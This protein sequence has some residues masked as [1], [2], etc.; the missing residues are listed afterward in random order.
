M[1]LQSIK[2]S[3]QELLIRVDE[4]PEIIDEEEYC[5]IVSDKAGVIKKINVQNGMAAVKVGDTVNVN[6][7]SKK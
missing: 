7:Q 3:V 6:S 2:F 5:N 1:V 4:K